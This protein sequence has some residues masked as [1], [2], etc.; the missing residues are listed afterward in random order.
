[1]V[2]LLQLLLAMEIMPLTYGEG[3]V[4]AHSLPSTVS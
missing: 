3:I 2:K 1:M 4:V